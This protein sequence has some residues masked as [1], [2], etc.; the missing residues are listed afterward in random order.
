MFL[1]S[2]IEFGN[3]QGDVAVF[4]DRPENALP[5]YFPT[6]IEKQIQAHA[7]KDTGFIA[8][9][10]SIGEERFAGYSPVLHIDNDIVINRDIDPVLR[11]IATQEGICVTTEERIYPELRSATISKVQDTRRIGNWWGLEL[12]RVDQDCGDEVLPLANG[13]IIG[14]KDHNAFRLVADLVCRLYRHP[15]HQNLVKYFGDQP[16][17]NYVL[18]KTQLGAYEPLRDTCIFTGAWQPFPP[19]RRGFLHFSWARGEDK[20]KYMKLYLD[21]LRAEQAQSSPAQE[22]KAL[23]W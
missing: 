13:E 2:L 5:K 8:R 11:A 10:S 23:P 9:Y 20:F 16:L 14:F 6:Q 4:A 1:E 21:H 18:V 3:Y 12:L 7:L 22:A 19:E 17:L 15:A